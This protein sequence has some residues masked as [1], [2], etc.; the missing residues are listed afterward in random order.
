LR[1]A[2]VGAGQVAKDRIKEAAGVLTGNKL[3]SKDKADQTVQRDQ[4][5]R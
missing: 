4:A 2:I 3:H 1:V 5:S